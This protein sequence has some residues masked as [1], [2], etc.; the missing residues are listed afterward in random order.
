MI[1]NGAMEAG[2][3]TIRLNDL[4]AIRD[5]HGQQQEP[6]TPLHTYFDGAG[7][8][9]NDP[10]PQLEQGMVFQTEEEL[11]ITLPS[12]ARDDSVG[13][14]SNG[15]VMAPQETVMSPTVLAFPGTPQNS[16]IRLP[17]YSS[18]CYYEHPP[19]PKASNV[20]IL[21][22]NH[23]T[24]DFNGK[25][26]C[27]SRDEQQPPT[28][29]TA[30][31]IKMATSDDIN[32]KTMNTSSSLTSET[33]SHR[34]QNK[35]HRR[36]H[37]HHHA[38]H[39][40]SNGVPSDAVAVDQLTSRLSNWCSINIKTKRRNNIYTATDPQ[41]QQKGNQHTI[42]A[43]RAEQEQEQTPPPPPLV[44]SYP[45][46]YR[47]SLYNPS[48]D[49]DYSNHRLSRHIRK[50]QCQSANK[51]VM[52]TLRNGNKM[53]LG[54]AGVDSDAIA[55]RRTASLAPPSFLCIMKETNSTEDVV[56]PT[57]NVVDPA[58]LAEAETSNTSHMNNRHTDVIMGE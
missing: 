43:S 34:K 29:I 50:L 33:K 39:H 15:T 14:A 46:A 27:A 3:G 51:E 58:T 18:S 35:H 37:H 36:R 49:Y 26:I 42:D 53:T 24:F 9:C 21:R 28:T 12:T 19:T 8:S 55:D 32:T 17:E 16:K 25:T 5:Q 48:Q 57:R 11:N 31:T 10:R 22:N 52:R 40:H 20:A 44:A 45:A 30:D 4:S 41:Q 56:D 47:S 38:N 7:G 2:G 54:D 13:R 1:A 23:S 6:K